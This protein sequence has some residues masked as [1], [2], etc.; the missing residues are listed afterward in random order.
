MSETPISLA[1]EDDLSEAVLRK[2]IGASGQPYAVGSAYGKSGFGY[3]KKRISAFNNAAKGGPWLVL[4]DLDQAECPPALIEEWFGTLSRQHNLIF[5]VAVREIEAWL[6]ADRPAFA[7]F[8]GLRINLI[9]RDVEA[10]QDPKARLIAL[11]SQSRRTSLREGIVPPRGRKQGPDYN[12][13]L[14]EYVLKYWNP[15]DA[16]KHSPS[17][18]RLIRLLDT[19]SPVWPRLALPGW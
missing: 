6:L 14:A 3:L 5:Q 13:R 2:I 11:V 12:G 9:P 15:R 18:E 4:T 19:F 10:I 1:V 8:T 16:M 17:L 7:R